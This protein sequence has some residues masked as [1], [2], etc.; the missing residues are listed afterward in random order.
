MNGEYISKNKINRRSY[1]E[2]NYKVIED[3]NFDNGNFGGNE[4]IL[5][6]DINVI[7]NIKSK[8][9]NEDI[10][11]KNFEK[12]NILDNLEEIEQLNG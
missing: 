7:K 3:E 5:I 2:L 6:N 8:G 10:N 11:N 12:Q 1:D 4:Q 9:Y